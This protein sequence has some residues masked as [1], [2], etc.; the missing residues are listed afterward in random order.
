LRS[1]TNLNSEDEVSGQ[2]GDI[3]GRQTTMATPELTLTRPDLV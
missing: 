1:P 3:F 2:V